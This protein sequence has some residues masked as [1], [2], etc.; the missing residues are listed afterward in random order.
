MTNPKVVLEAL[1]RFNLTGIEPTA[2]IDIHR[3]VFLFDIHR[4]HT[5]TIYRSDIHH[6][7][8]RHWSI[9]G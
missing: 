5:I 8:H 7:P 1:G 2:H 6:S 4:I 3:R 9:V